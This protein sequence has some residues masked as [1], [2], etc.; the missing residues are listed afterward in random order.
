V[1]RSPPK[2]GVSSRYRFGNNTPAAKEQLLKALFWL[3]IGQQKFYQSN[4]VIL[5]AESFSKKVT[6]S[7]F[8]GRTKI[9]PVFT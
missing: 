4:P 1:E 3:L 7:N 2:I 5:V 6:D 8:N 9:K